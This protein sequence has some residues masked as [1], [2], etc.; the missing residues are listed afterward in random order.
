MS[1][2]VTAIS[3]GLQYNQISIDGLFQAHVPACQC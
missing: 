1:I 3:G 2:F